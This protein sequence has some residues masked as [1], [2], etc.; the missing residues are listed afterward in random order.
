[1]IGAPWPWN[2]E[3]RKPTPTEVGVR[4]GERQENEVDWINKGIG[5]R[6]STFQWSKVEAITCQNYKTNT[7]VLSAFDTNYNK[8][9]VYKN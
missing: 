3:M 7:L 9:I 6:S 2:E 1:M 4:D 8:S 5:Q